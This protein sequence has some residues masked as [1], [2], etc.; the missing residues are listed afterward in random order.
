VDGILKRNAQVRVMRDGAVAYTGQLSSLKRFKE[1]VG[2]VRTGFECGASISN[3][4]DVKVG[5]TLECFTSVR[6]QHSEATA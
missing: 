5:D 2:E 4:N 6:V 1:D 3:F